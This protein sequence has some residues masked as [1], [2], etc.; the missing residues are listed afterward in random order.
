MSARDTQAPDYL[1]VLVP[2]A[3]LALLIWWMVH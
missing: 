1:A 3:G 2:L